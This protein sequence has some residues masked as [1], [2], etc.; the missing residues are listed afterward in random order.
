MSFGRFGAIVAAGTAGS[1]GVVFAAVADPGTRAAV[2]LGA[3]IAALNVLA[4]YALVVWSEGRST[5]TFLR[6][7]LGGMAAR[8]LLALAAI[9]VAIRSFGVPAMPLA[10]SA[11]AY[12]L[13]L[14]ALETAV[15]HRSLAHPRPELR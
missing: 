15:V 7:L 4:G 8:L 2:G 12:S 11:L 1:L 10:L 6:A 13:V 9:A 3:L 5:T 14:L